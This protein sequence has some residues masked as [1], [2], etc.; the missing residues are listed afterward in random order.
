MKTNN[1]F[2]SL[3]LKKY[4]MY[5]MISLTCILFVHAALYKYLGMDFFFYY[6]LVAGLFGGFVL[7]YIRKLTFEQIEPFINLY[8]I[9]ESLFLLLYA[10]CFWEKTP[11]AFFWFFIIPF[12]S[13][14]IYSQRFTIYW[15]LYTFVLIG[16]TVVCSG[17][18]QELPIIRYINFPPNGTTLVNIFA[19]ISILF[20]FASGSYFGRKINILNTSVSVINREEEGGL[21]GNISD[22]QNTEQY[23]NEAKLKKLYDEILVYF[24]DYQPYHKP[25][26]SIIHL[27][28]ALDTNVTYISKAIKLNANTGFI[29][30]VNRYRIALVKQLINNNEL[31]KHSLLYV[32]TSAGFKHQSTFNKVFKQI[33][34]ITPTEYLKRNSEDPKEI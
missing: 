2:L 16:L 29:T 12:F 20:L 22:N 27:A 11:I 33:E 31:E 13:M 1:T 14:N 26:F 18:I 3:L 28:N 25:D 34:G 21:E 17:F 32:Y 23:E 5:Q 8:L 19:L 9:F 4:I 15:I 6:N 30:F 7:I 10:M 24:N